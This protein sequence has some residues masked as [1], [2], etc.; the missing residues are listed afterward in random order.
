MSCIRTYFVMAIFTLRTC[1]SFET[2]K[3]FYN[4]LLCIC[5]VDIIILL[6]EMLFNIKSIKL[7]LVVKLK[8]S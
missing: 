2:V 8:L 5:I 1:Q 4:F 7:K 3:I 6:P